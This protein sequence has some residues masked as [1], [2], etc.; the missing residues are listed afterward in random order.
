MKYPPMYSLKKHHNLLR[1]RAM[2]RADPSIR[3]IRNGE[4][5]KRWNTYEVSRE[6]LIEDMKQDIDA[7][8]SLL[9]EEQ[10]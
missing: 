5:T 4:V 1:N 6:S 9:V 10:S 2:R 8:K 3:Q 7:G